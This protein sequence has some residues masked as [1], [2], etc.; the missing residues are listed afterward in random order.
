[1][2]LYSYE[3]AGYAGTLVSVEVDIKRGIPSTDV[4]GLAGNAV[5][6]ARD[7]VR[8]A[9]RNS[10]FAYPM[11]RVLVSLAPSDVPKS[12]SGLDLA[13]A[14]AVLSASGQTAA[15]LDE[16]VL[17]VGELHLGGAVG[18]VRG[19]IAALSEG[20][21]V[22][23]RRFVIPD[24]NAEE[25][26]ALD[27]GSVYPVRS[28]R[29]A[30]DVLRS[31]DEARSVRPAIDNR[32]I[33]DGM[34][35]DQE[36]HTFAGAADL[37]VGTG[38][39]SA[40]RGHAPLK[41]AAEVA[42][43]GGHH[44][45]MVGPPGSGKSMAASLLPSVLPPLT[46]GE[47]IEA[48]RLHSL[49][50]TLPAGQ[51]LLRA[52]PYRAPH[53]GA[54]VEGILGGGRSVEPGEASLAHRGV[55]FLDE[56]P[57]FR[58]NV[59]Q[60]LREP[61]EER[62]VRISRAGRTYWFPAAVQLVL[63]CNP[64]PCGLLGRDDAAC[65]CSMAEIDRY[66]RRVGGALLDRIDVRSRVVPSGL[67]QSEQTDSSAQMRNRIA[68]ARGRQQERYAGREVRLNGELSG[69]DIRS[70]VPLDAPISSALEEVTR[71][72]R[73]SNRGVVS[74]LRLAR[75]IADLADRDT[76]C[77]ADVF[78]AAAHRRLGEDRPIWMSF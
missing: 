36:A 49:A 70:V 58:R 31:D 29:K 45:L 63:A 72:L 28:L 6:E 46:Q 73:L 9:V 52:R 23:I 54:T 24:G 51:G 43:A 8:V 53:H 77:D 39:Y 11:D 75:T 40:L 30:V 32:D 1:M 44:L 64:C 50:G 66:W 18:P 7:R 25:A 21:A 20:A 15:R 59:L 26:H 17:V 56:A 74:V 5:R 48:T 78:E 71:H 12:G 35:T 22:G 16:A 2:L 37:Y 67:A 69:S 68:R 60:G 33:R 47:A 42:V 38:D 55:L 41:R 57:E 4:V 10:G 65:V 34:D 76:V 3:P 61:L 13:I 14:L 27:V 19:V 62:R